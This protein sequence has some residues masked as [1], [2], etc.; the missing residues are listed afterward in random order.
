MAL[1]R[2]FHGSECDRARALASHALDTAPAELD[3]AAL[4]VHL[5]SCSD[6]AQAV[7]VMEDVT[8]RLRS[9]PAIAPSRTLQPS[10]AP[11]MVRRRRRA[12]RSAY[13]LI[14]VTATVAAAAA[15][16]MVASHS[17]PHPTT[18]SHTIVVAERAPLDH[19]FRI[20]RAGQLQLRLPPPKTHSPHAHDVIV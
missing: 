15:G 7:A 2:Y 10:P 14:G 12:G 20:I 16:A 4:R 3:L 1:P 5:R 8:V 9:A 19:E 18:G 13:R 17:R 6:C 11:L